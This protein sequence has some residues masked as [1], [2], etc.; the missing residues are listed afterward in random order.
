MKFNT[1]YGPHVGIC[2]L[3]CFVGVGR[4]DTPHLYLVPILFHQFMLPRLVRRWV[5]EAKAPSV[6]CALP[7][8]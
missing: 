1:N 2:M 8:K 3:V 6:L 7:C 5:V 4:M